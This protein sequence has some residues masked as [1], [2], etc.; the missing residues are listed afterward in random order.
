M[1]RALFNTAILLEGR[2]DS[3]HHVTALVVAKE[4][5]LGVYDANTA[6]Y[7]KKYHDYIISKYD[8]PNTVGSIDATLNRTLSDMVTLAGE[9]VSVTHQAVSI[10]GVPNELLESD[11][12]YWVD[13]ELSTYCGLDGG[14][15]DGYCTYPERAFEGAAS[16]VAGN[17]TSSSSASATGASSSSAEAT[18][19]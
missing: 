7:L 9:I 17:H 6:E 5:T 12:R 15:W 16:L 10:G 11:I 19:Y 3:Q 14:I 18:W 2:I 13:V 4:R 1:N 8:I